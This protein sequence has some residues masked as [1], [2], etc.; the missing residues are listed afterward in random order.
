MENLKLPESFDWRDKGFNTPVRYQGEE[1]GSCWAFGAAQSIEA[2]YFL[3]HKKN[4]NLSVQNLID[5]SWE[6]DN[7]GCGGG[8]HEY[9]FEYILDNK[10]IAFDE[11]YPYSEVDGNCTYKSCCKAVSLQDFFRVTPKNENHMKQVIATRG[12]LVCSVY[13]S[14]DTFILYK[15]GFYD[16]EEC[17]KEEVNHSVLVVG[18]GTYKDGDEYWIIKNSWDSDWGEN[19]YMRIPRNKNNFCGIADE[20]SFPSL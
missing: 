1:C 14:P 11:S 16:D 5:C 18:Y 2:Q 17:N 7:E 13:A 8:F 15:E 4:I 9:A 20:C 3:K 10:G 19:G 12:P 6:Y